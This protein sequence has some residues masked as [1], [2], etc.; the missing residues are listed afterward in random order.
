W[1]SKVVLGLKPDG[2]VSTKERLKFTVVAVD[3]AGKPM[4]GVRVTT[5]A[6]QR[7]SFSH[8]RRLIGGFY[9]YEHGYETKR[10]GALC[11]GTTDSLGLLV[12]E[13]PP[14]AT[15]NLILRARA[16][17]GDGRTAVTRTD[18]WVASDEDQWLAAS[19]N[20]RIDLLPEAKRYEP[21]ARARF[22]VRTPFR[23][24]TALVT[25]EREGVLDAFVT[26]VDRTNPL[27]EVP[28]KG[29]YA[30]NVFVS[31]L[32]VR[33]RIGEPAPTAMLDLAKPSFKMG[34]A[35]LRVGWGAH[36]L[37][38]KVAPTREAY[39]TREKA[40]VK[41]A[42]RRPDGSAPPRGSE[43]ALAAVDEGLLEL[44]PNASWKLLDAMMAR[45][46]EEVETATAQMQVIGRRHFGRKA[47]PPGGGGGRSPSR[48]LFDTLLVWKARVMLDDAGDATVEV[49][50]NDSLTSFRIVAVA[51]SASGLFGTGE[52]TIRAT[53]DLMLL[54]GLPQLVREGDRFRATFTVRNASQRTLD[55]AVTPRATAGGAA[56]PDVDARSLVLAAGE[57][58][59]IAW[60]V[61]APAGAS[62]I[63]WQLDAAER[64][65]TGEPA[66]DALKVTQ[67]VVPAVPERTWQATIVQLVSPQSV[68]VE[69]P[70]DAIPGRGGVNV[71]VQGKLAGDLP[72]VR[73]YLS[74]YPYTCF[75]QRASVAIGLRDPALWS[76]A[77]AALPDYLDRDG[78]VKY[79][80]LLRDGDDVLTSYLLSVASEAG[81]A[82]PERERMRMEQALVGFVEG[83]VIRSSALPTADLS[84]RKVAALEALSRRKDPIDA[85]WLDSIAIEPNLWP[86]SAVIDWYLV[87]KRQ[88]KLP[89]HDERLKAAEQ[90]L[91]SR[92]AFQGTT[93]GFS[94]EKTDALWWLMVSA[95]ANANKL[96]VAMHDVPA[97]R[98]DVP[99]MVRG[100]LGRMQKGH[101]NTTVANAWGVVALGKFSARFEAAPVTGTTEAKLAETS[102]AHAWKPDD[103]A[104][105][106][107]KRLGWPAAKSELTVTH[108]G[109]GTP[110]VTLQSIAAIPLTAP[111]SSG[112]RV[113][114]TVTPVRQQSAGIW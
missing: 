98:D 63:A 34:L 93:M 89:R 17:D 4:P 42:V 55:L 59:E 103:G 39:K 104:K 95:D 30:P 68:A 20:D 106:F 99:R 80:T 97:W 14:P 27:L 23:E 28:L 71:Q 50:L 69:R 46:G 100:S 36:E 90:V 32:L 58:R 105:P 83:R 16:S 78:M 52:A 60:D 85:K 94:T 19:D 67:K 91:R 86:T 111:L 114:R 77:M 70:A 79:W 35:E 76:A 12:C 8:R 51:S 45:R 6:F 66:K 87:L 65:A 18:A 110:W 112:Y 33:G 13:M 37:A 108:D 15:G 26:K 92:L 75:E 72:G 48:E 109:T 21:D 5:D 57:A 49:P 101:W 38:V 54:S 41:I 43:V 74:A 11:E 113:T 2:W 61:A 22:Q 44:A 107:S 62:S 73:E 9:A 96:I 102:F 31:A 81:Y 47:V 7:E 3:L 64:E 53:Q 56:I 40:S 84:I 82:I 29:N 88:P 1:P 25:V 10:V 24:A